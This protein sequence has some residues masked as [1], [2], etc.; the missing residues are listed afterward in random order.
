MGSV[1]RPFDNRIPLLPD[2]VQ[3]PVVEWQHN[4]SHG[5][6]ERLAALVEGRATARLLP[7]PDPTGNAPVWLNRG[8]LR[9]PADHL[10]PDE[11]CNNRRKRKRK[12]S[13][14]VKN[15]SHR[16]YKKINCCGCACRNVSVRRWKV[17]KSCIL[18]IQPRCQISCCLWI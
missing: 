18:Y 6:C 3:S 13:K 8:S 7:E 14:S 10:Q 11:R 2:S 4:A 15:T 5:R 17:W 1:S 16:N 12:K 9:T